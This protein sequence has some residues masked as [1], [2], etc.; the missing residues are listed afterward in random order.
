MRVLFASAHKYLPEMRGGME[1]NTH[2]LAKRLQAKGIKIG[3]MSGLRGQ[4]ITGLNA[5]LQTKVLRRCCSRD[6]WLGYPVWRAYDSTQIAEHVSRT[7]KP[8]IVVL[9]GGHEF[10]TLTR[11]FLNIGLPVVGYLHSP[12]RLPLDDDLR[13]DQRLAFLCNS[14]FTASLHPGKKTAAILPPIVL[15]EKY[16]TETD[17]SSAVF[18][19]PK[20]YKGLDIVISLAQARP[21][22]PFLVVVNHEDQLSTRPDIPNVTYLGPY[23]DMRVVYRRARIILAPSQWEETWG[24][25]ATEAQISGIPVLASNRGGLPEAVGAGGIC[26]PADSPAEDWLAALSEL[27]DDETRYQ[28]YSRAAFE[29]SRRPI[30]QPDVIIQTFMKVLSEHMQAQ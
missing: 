8:D 22:I 25:I 17:R 24:R 5:I 10:L 27:W 4:G 14:E 19:N 1:I 6:S 3:V 18:I 29:H 13:D 30:I 16:S 7:F 12:D 20:P 23:D 11:Q 28:G 9:Q 2:H 26:L 15:R 21:D